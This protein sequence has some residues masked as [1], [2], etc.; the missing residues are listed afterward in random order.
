MEPL[1]PALIA[2]LTPADVE[3]RFYDDRMELIP[4]D[5]PTDLVA[6][7]IE[8]YTAKRCYQIA[9][10]YR[11]RGVPVV[12]G[13]FHASLIPEEV[14][15]Y[16]ESIVIGEAEGVWQELIEDYRCGTPKKRYQRA[17]GRPDL[18][19]SRPDR[20]IFEGKRYLPIGLV[21]AGRGC[22]FRCEFCA[23][24]T[25]FNKTQTRRPTMDILD[26]LKQ[27]RDQK[28]LIFFVDDNITSN[29]RQAKEF[30]RALKPLNLRWVSQAS[31]N[32]AHDEEFLTILRE[33]GCQ[34]VLI[35]FESLNPE[36]L[37]RMDKGFNTMKGGYEVALANLRKHGIRL[38]VTFV[39]GYDQ[40]TVA[41]FDESVEFAK[42]HAFYITA[43]NHLTPFPGTPLYKRLQDEGRLLYDAWWL[44]ERYSYNMIPF[45]P[46]NISPEE[47]Q[48]RCVG[49]RASFYS[50]RSILRRSLDPVNRSDF[51]MWRN[52][53]LIN[54][55]HRADVSLRDYYPLGDA[56]WT[57]EILPAT[58]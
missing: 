32:A 49:A 36:N 30:F 22:H 28:K 44:D 52:F 13:G 48:R 12:M 3:L 17:D 19:G 39:F 7:S 42:R 23:V 55:L 27:I 21:E 18:A 31:I 33:S 9:S 29:M 4:F 25:V 14:E 34:G 2:A 53:Y 41:S 5:E 46:A 8:T 43:F 54:G 24:Q 50:R 40:D 20:S 45:Q 58:A 47:L 26:E 57:G 51:F 56:A 10:E 6:M 15:Q 16:A 37:K 1:P 11:K 38:Y 35:G